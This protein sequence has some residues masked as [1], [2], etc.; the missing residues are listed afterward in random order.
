MRKAFIDLG[1]GSGDD[2]KGFYQLDK[3]H[4]DWEIFAFE[5]NPTRTKG[6]KQ[7]YPNASVFTAAAGVNSGTFKL[8]LGNH[9]NTSSLKV[10]KKSIDKNNYINVEVVDLIKWMKSEFSEDDQI[11]MVID[12]EGSEY[13]ILN[14]L[15][16]EGMWEWIDELYVEFHGEKLSNFD[17]EIENNLCKDLI[18]FYQN[19]VYIFRKHQHEMFLR[20]NAEGA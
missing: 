11:I 20:L 9:P 5:P 3:N 7:R 17:I 13:D 6:I 2:I 10:E 19:R 18:E 16:E 15:R 8:Y 1:A 12:V 14:R 4:A